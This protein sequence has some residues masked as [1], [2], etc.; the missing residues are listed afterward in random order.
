MNFSA[1]NSGWFFSLVNRPALL[2]GCVLFGSGGISVSAGG[3][4]KPNIVIFIADDLTWHDVAALGGPT[5]VKTPHL[6]R[7]AR[8]GIKFTG[9]YSPASVCSPSRQAL[10]TGLYPVR[11]GAYPNHARLNDG[12]R[13]LPHYLKPLGYRTASLGKRHYDPLD[14][15]PFDVLNLMQSPQEEASTDDEGDFDVAVLERFIKADPGRPF[16]AYLATHEPHGPW[17]KGDPSAFDPAKIKLPPYL[18]DTPET[19][20]A[21]VAYYAEVALV[22]Q[23]VGSVMQVLEK[24]GN[25]ANTLFLFVSEQGSGVPHSKWTLY[26]PG[27]RVAA[28]A[29]W[30]GKITA[31]T[32]SGALM[33]Y[34]DVLPT[35]IAA[36]GGDPTQ[37]DT[38]CPDT[39]GYT[40]FDGRS[41]LG[42][43]LGQTD[44]LRDVVFA[45][46]TTRGI[47][48]GSEAYASRA[49]S[50]GRWKLIVNLH[51]DQTFSNIIVNDPILKSWRRAGEQGDAFAAQQAARYTHRPS[52]ELYDLRTDPWE[53]TNVADQTANDAI[54]K[55][56]R[57]QLDAWMKQQG[58]E[59]DATERAATDHQAGKR[60]TAKP[61]KEKS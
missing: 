26:D 4:A 28:I 25:A 9:F 31:G 53:L 8:E 37:A 39:L 34:V 19:R 1:I 27:I 41:F 36:A 56:L 43:L 3:S 12:V 10:L 48:Q 55:R 46:H 11:S 45:Q 20:K 33:Q 40:G 59:G 29:R 13:T 6:D 60:S 38:G 22:D 23:Q 49:V 57:A 51:A 24:T 14:A 21:L 30:P 58:D 5:N 32:A 2:V 44:Q 61:R 17:N 42:V 47:K 7:L 18:A 50:D 54:V 16:C 35:L 15:Y 52:L